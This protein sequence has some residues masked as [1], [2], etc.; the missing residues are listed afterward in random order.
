[1]GN[2]GLGMQLKTV[3]KSILVYFSICVASV[4]VS[5]AGILA[6]DAWQHPISWVI[7]T[8]FTSGQSLFRPDPESGFVTRANVKAVGG[9]TT[10]RRSAEV[11]SLLRTLI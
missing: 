4:T 6:Y 5:I 1:M 10:K 11:G 9:H 2:V 8:Q 7:G 3:L